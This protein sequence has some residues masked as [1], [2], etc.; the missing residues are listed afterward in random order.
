M[1]LPYEDLSKQA[2]LLA[3]A[4]RKRLELRGNDPWAV[5][6]K[7]HGFLSGRMQAEL[8]YLLEARKMATHPKLA[9]QI[10]MERIKSAVRKISEQLR[11]IDIPR[12]RRLRRFAIAT[13]IMVNLALV[14]AAA[15]AFALWRGA[16]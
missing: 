8:D 6:E 13:T 16:L 3:T 5:L 12:Q 15:V 14:A 11:K 9:L 2:E 4:M 7:G 1:S 10:D